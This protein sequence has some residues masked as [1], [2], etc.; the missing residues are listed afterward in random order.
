MGALDASVAAVLCGPASQQ[1]DRSDDMC[2]LLRAIRNLQV[3]TS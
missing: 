1:S 2:E 3:M